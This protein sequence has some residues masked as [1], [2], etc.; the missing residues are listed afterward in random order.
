MSLW[1]KTAIVTGA[2]S[3]IGRAT[4][5]ALARAGCDVVLA[6]RRE[7]LLRDVA[8]EIEMLGRQALVQVTDVADRDQV[9]RLIDETLVRFG[10]IDVLVNNAG[11]G[12]EASLEETP[13][14]E[15]ER[16]VAVNFLG[17]AYASRAALPAM[18]RQGRGY[19]VN[20]ASPVGRRGIPMNA[21]YSAAKA[22]VIALSEALR[23]ELKGSGI[24]VSTVLPVDTSTEFFQVASH[25]RRKSP[26]A[27]SAFIQPPERVAAA[28][29]QCVQRPREE[30][31]LSPALRP[32]LAL[33]VLLPSLSDWGVLRYLK[34]W[35]TRAATRES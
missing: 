32:A 18:R 30:V 9:A 14:E 35:H 5:I 19:I 33:S 11:Y 22:A 26:A 8:A 15:I 23:L 21:T 12:Y 31:L 1:G 27:P 34:L 3:G 2:S 10:H 7:P 6:A 24:Y 17:T 28:I 16:L 13:V 20:V 25:G 4:A 29:V